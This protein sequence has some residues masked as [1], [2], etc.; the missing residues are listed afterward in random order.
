MRLYTVYI[1]GFA[2]VSATVEVKANDVDEA[3][4]FA[5]EYTKEGK[6]I[7]DVELQKPAPALTARQAISQTGR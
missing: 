3:K 5:R 6:V 2:I 1:T 4:R 7:W